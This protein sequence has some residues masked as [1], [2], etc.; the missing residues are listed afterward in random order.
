MDKPTPEGTF[1]LRERIALFTVTG[2]AGLLA[3]GLIYPAYSSVTRWRVYHVPLSSS[4]ASGNGLKAHWGLSKIFYKNHGWKDLYRGRLHDIA[5]YQ[6]NNLCLIMTS[7]GY[8]TSILSYGILASTTIVASRFLSFDSGA[9][10]KPALKGWLIAIAARLLVL[11]LEIL[12]DRMAIYGGKVG[13]LMT[14]EEKANPLKHIFTSSLI[15]S[16]CANVWVDASVF[17]VERALGMRNTLE[18]PGRTTVLLRAAVLAVIN[19]VFNVIFARL[20][21]SPLAV[22]SQQSAKSP[23]RPKV[24]KYDGIIDCVQRLVREEGVGALFRG[25]Y[26]EVAAAVFQASTDL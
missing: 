25:W 8:G 11:P 24:V 21:A 3:T 7:T 13:T 23:G 10:D 9:R 15:I 4:N 22:V 14:P 1:G 17:F 20:N 26:F 6:M 19:T 18:K 2:S 16:G 5:S 12:A